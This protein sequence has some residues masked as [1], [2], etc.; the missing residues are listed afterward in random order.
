MS[1]RTTSRAA[2]LIELEP[3]ELPNLGDAVVATAAHRQPT[4]P[5]F[6]VRNL[7]TVMS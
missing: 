4:A 5:T 7:Y 3:T 2:E 1:A 6:I